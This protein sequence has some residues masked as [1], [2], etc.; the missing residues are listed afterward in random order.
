VAS[1]RWWVAMATAVAVATTG[2]AAATPR[3]TAQPRQPVSRP[4]SLSPSAGS[5]VA[6]TRLRVTAA[7]PGWEPLTRDRR[8]VVIDRR[9]VGVGYG[10]T[11]L[12]TRFRAGQTSFALHAGSVDP[13]WQAYRLGVVARS[14]VTAKERSLLVAT[15][16]GGFA[17]NSGSGG[18]VQE[19]HVVAPLKS[20][21]ASLVIDVG[22]AAHVG[23]WMH[24][25]PLPGERVFSVRQNLAALVLHG[26]PSPQVGDVQAAWG[27]TLGGGAAVARTALGE[28]R[29]GN[30]LFAGSM[31]VTPAELA[32]ALVR[33]GAQT[34]ME[35]DINPEWVQ[36]DYA[37]APGGSLN[38]GIPG[39][40]RPADQYL[41]GWTR[42]FI[43]VTARPGAP[44]P[45]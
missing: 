26:R 36:F 33:A 20:G 19:R 18:Y 42:D 2:C 39:Q 32:A 45:R 3:G 24:G 27:A 44:T 38:A 30:L 29:S 15:F 8:G 17:L 16:T 13:G 23:V 37:R 12:V 7:A 9:S 21:L 11:V 6:S 43:A 1:S 22:G 34:A 4:E 28:D 35:L 31:S 25:L 40:H 41:L 10:R 5:R 14:V